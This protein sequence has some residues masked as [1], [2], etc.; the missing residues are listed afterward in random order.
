MTSFWILRFQDHVIFYYKIEINNGR[1][2]NVFK[3]H[4]PKIPSNCIWNIMCWLPVMALHCTTFSVRTDR[5]PLVRTHPYYLQLLLYLWDVISL[6]NYRNYKSCKSIR[7]SKN[8]RGQYLQTEAGED[9]FRICYKL[10]SI[11][12][13]VIFNVI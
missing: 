11:S 1:V 13:H 6:F 9:P 10:V 7:A 4:C 3:S 2:C 12:I 5:P 8:W